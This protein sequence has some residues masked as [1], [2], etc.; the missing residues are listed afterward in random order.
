VTRGHDD[1]TQRLIF[2][3]FFPP[4]FSSLRRRS[5]VAPAAAAGEPARLPRRPLHL[6]G[7]PLRRAGP[8]RAAAPRVRRARGLAPP[9]RGAPRVRLRVLARALRRRL[10]RPPPTQ[11]PRFTSLINPLRGSS[12]GTGCS[13]RAPLLPIRF[14]LN[15]RISSLVGGGVDA[16]VEGEETARNAGLPALVRE[17]QRIDTIRH[18][19]GDHF[20]LSSSCLAL[21][22]CEMAVPD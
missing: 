11:I 7:G 22:R 8:R 16:E 12:P 14:G 18:Y 5:H 10:L 17:I 13:L 21:Y 20:F 19:A 4:V 15:S 9:P 1:P 6:P 2:F 3:F